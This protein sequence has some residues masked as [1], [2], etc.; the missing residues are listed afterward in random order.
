M[1]TRALGNEGGA[2]LQ[3][4]CSGSGPS[5]NFGQASTS[6]A[7]SCAQSAGRPDPD[8]VERQALIQFAG[9]VQRG[10]VSVWQ[11]LG[12]EKATEEAR[13]RIA[14]RILLLASHLQLPGVVSAC[15]LEFVKQDPSLWTLGLR[16]HHLA[17]ASV[18]GFAWTTSTTGAPSSASPPLHS[19]ATFLALTDL[20]YD[21]RQPKRGIRALPVAFAVLPPPPR[22]ILAHSWPPASRTEDINFA[23]CLSPVL[24]HLPPT[25]AFTLHVWERLY[26]EVQ[27]FVRS[28]REGCFELQWSILDAEECFIPPHSHFLDSRPEAYHPDEHLQ[29]TIFSILRDVHAGQQ[30][31]GPPGIGQ[32]Q[33]SF[34]HL[35]AI[36][37]DLDS[38]AP[39]ILLGTL[40]THARCILRQSALACR[41]HI[42][43]QTL[44]AQRLERAEALVKTSESVVLAH[45]DHL[46]SLHAVLVI[47]R[48]WRKWRPTSLLWTYPEEA[49]MFAG[50]QAAAL[51]I[52]SWV[53]SCIVRK[54]V[55]S[56]FRSQA[57]H[58]AATLIQSVLRS[59]LCMRMHTVTQHGQNR[60]KWCKGVG[61][62]DGT[63]RGVVRAGI[64]EGDVEG[65]GGDEGDVEGQGGDEGDVESQGGDEG[66]VE[67]Q[68]GDEGD[69]E[70]QGGDEG[71]VMDECGFGEQDK[72]GAVGAGEARVG[73]GKGE[74]Q[75]R[76]PRESRDSAGCCAVQ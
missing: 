54:A 52:Q 25:V 34:V 36:A 45:R 15:S 67:G 70:G 73:E 63:R 41:Q 68:G 13:A 74:G 6:G 42:G 55:L 49:V 65:Q 53:R 44:A 40:L 17:A 50:Q 12:K 35:P 28:L 30:P 60:L 38:D 19:A 10:D 72:G 37:A 29:Q 14:A 4:A 71:D 2:A 33:H 1:S 46:A 75:A 11:E 66:D 58:A 23:A 16:P 62:E 48:F 57:E 21:P 47:Q 26:D 31:A 64:D 24:A 20:G 9:L 32:S 61:G 5:H 7:A 59:Y 69:V 76:A 51:L 43:W 8:L 22:A 3:A 27:V 18:L 39:E 56:R